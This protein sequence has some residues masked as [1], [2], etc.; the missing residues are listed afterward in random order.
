MA[1]NVGQ[2]E[3][4]GRGRKTEAGERVQWVRLPV[5]KL[6]DLSLIPEIHLVEGEK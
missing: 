6:E 4:W 3:R 5:T 1:W 2:R